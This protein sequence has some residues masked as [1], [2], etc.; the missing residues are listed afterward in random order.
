MTSRG[1]KRETTRGLSFD[2]RRVMSLLNDNGAESSV[3]ACFRIT[4]ANTCW[5][6]P[7]QTHKVST[8]CRCNSNFKNHRLWPLYFHSDRNITT[9]HFPERLDKSNKPW[10]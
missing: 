1:I 9:S 8:G 3:K 4:E 10:M 7:K 2:T 6:F 5:T